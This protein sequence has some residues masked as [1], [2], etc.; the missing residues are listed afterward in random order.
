M[1]KSAELRF[2]Q[3][4]IEAQNYFLN[5]PHALLKSFPIQDEPEVKD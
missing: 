4:K 3:L 2:D 1:A 5:K